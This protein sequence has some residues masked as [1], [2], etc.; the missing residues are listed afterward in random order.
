MHAGLVDAGTFDG[1][2]TCPLYVNDTSFEVPFHVDDVVKTTNET[3]R[4]ISGKKAK[5][6]ADE[7]CPLHNRRTKADDNTCKVVKL[8]RH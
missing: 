2:I 6:C 3:F 5:E 7:F 4:V 1:N 8:T